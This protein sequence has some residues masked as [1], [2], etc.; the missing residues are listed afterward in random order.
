MLA[1]DVPAVAR[2]SGQLGY[3]S[4]EDQVRRR[5]ERLGPREDRATFV[6]VD[7][8]GRVIGW[9]HVAEQ[10]TIE[11]DPSGEVWGLVVDEGAR[12][13]RVGRLLMDAAERWARGRGLTEMCV[14]SNVVRVD[15]HR[16]YLAI[17]YEIAKT[18]HK[19]RRR[20]DTGEAGPR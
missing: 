7:G 2:L 14:R 17:G 8:A 6:A 15:A 18:Q 19:F 13:R 11:A 9:V 12:N 3:P 20:L 1:S 4:S 5:H 16:F 10:G